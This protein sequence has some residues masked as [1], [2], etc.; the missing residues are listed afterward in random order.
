[1]ADEIVIY[2]QRVKF[3]MTAQAKMKRV[4]APVDI[5]PSHG[6]GEGGGGLQRVLSIGGLQ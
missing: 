1:M 3:S 2:K 5:E 6:G 4:S